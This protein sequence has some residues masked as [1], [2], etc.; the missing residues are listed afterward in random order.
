MSTNDL[1][2]RASAT[3]S[4]VTDALDSRAPPTLKRHIHAASPTS[5]LSLSLYFLNRAYA[6][7]SLGVNC[8]TYGFLYYFCGGVPPSKH[9]RPR[10]K[11]GYK[12]A[13]FITGAH[14]G[15]GRAIAFLLAESGWTVFAGV[16]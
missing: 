1:R 11:E 10:P 2:L 6:Y 12:P 4:K 16:K 13:V 14:D 7:W 5:T 8:L 15:I 3:A 9:T